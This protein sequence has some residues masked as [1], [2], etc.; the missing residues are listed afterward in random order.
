MSKAAMIA[1][2]SDASSQFN[3]RLKQ[4]KGMI[5]ERLDRQVAELHLTR[6]QLDTKDHAIKAACGND[7][8]FKAATDRI[9][10]FRKKE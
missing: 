2:G 7:P 5:M 1:L 6:D 4:R 10:V 8:A 3:E 9:G